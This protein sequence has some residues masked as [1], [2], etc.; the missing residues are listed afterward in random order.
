MERII[1]HIDVNNAFLSWEAVFR[2]NCLHENLDIRTIPAAIGGDRE[3]RRGI[4]LAKSMPAKKYGIRTAE[5]IVDALR[6]CPELKIFPGRF[7]FYRECSGALIDI[8]SEYTDII[9]QMSIDEA[10]ADFSENTQARE[11]PVE[12]A[13]MLRK[14]V[15]NELGFTVNIGV[16]HNKLLAKMASDFTKPDRVHTLFAEEIPAKMWPLSVSDL[17][18]VGASTAK[19]LNDFGIRTIGELAASDPDMLSHYFGKNAYGLKQSANGIDDSP[20]RT[21]REDNKGYGNS[22]TLPSNITDCD[23]AYRVLLSLCETVG[24]RIRKDDAHIKVISVSIRDGDF[25][26]WSH[27]TTLDNATNVTS[28]LY[29]KACELFDKTWDGVK[30]IR[31]LG[32]HTSGVTQDAQ[33]QYS[34]FDTVDYSQQ[35]KAEKLVDALRQKFGKDSVVRASLLRKDEH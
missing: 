5:P 9:E 6:K 21:E 2:L 3:Q 35:E 20:V 10:A 16:A 4:I 14:R 12:F 17:M 11:N 25:K 24:A 7:D 34:L 27:Q 22:T 1:M 28:E 23:E 29:A 33:R 32:V 8:I 31:A 18:F 15:F 13:N 19:R 30:P 26:K